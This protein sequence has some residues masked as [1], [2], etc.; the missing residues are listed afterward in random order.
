MNK[1]TFFKSFALLAAMLLGGGNLASA[2]E[3]PEGYE[4]KNVYYGTQSGN[5]VTPETFSELTADATK[6]GWDVSQLYSNTVGTFAIASVDEVAKPEVG[7]SVEDGV[8]P[9]YVSGNTLRIS[10]RGSS[11][12][13]YAI[14]SFDEISSGILVFTGDIFLSGS[15]DNNTA[16]GP[17]LHF[18][19]S[20]GNNVFA[21]GFNSGSGSQRFSYTIGDGSV[22]SVTT[23]PATTPR[24]YI[25]WGVNELSVNLTTGDLSITIDYITDS[26][27]RTQQ[28]LNL[29]IGLG[30][31]ISKFQF[32]RAG[33]SKVDA[34]THLDN[35]SLY[36]VGP[37][38]GIFNYTVKAKAGDTE[39]ATLASGTCKGGMSYSVSGLP[40]VIKAEDKYYILDDE[41]VS[42]Y[43]KSFTMGEADEEQTI[44]YT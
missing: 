12:N 31:S 11:S 5:V 8:V 38:A 35:F 10:Q 6:S 30:K 16:D 2:Y 4:V 37:E 22:Q 21:F 41:T 13:K 32:G 27:V 24:T 15:G 26:K 34:N 14:Y 23:I 29:N 3:V 43:G 20:E 7:E 18:L 17:R 9:T 42:S 39:L 36:T 25:G 1:T 33:R 19:D 28:T 44:N 40:L